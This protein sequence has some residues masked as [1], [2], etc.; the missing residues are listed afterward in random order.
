MFEGKLEGEEMGSE[1]LSSS[2]HS[3][4]MSPSADKENCCVLL[5]KGSPYRVV[6]ILI[7]FLFLTIDVIFYGIIFGLNKLKGSIYING[8]VAGCADIVSAGLLALFAERIPRKVYILTTWA[9]VTV[10]TL[11]YH[12]CNKYQGIEYAAVLLGKLGAT[13]T[14]SMIFFIAVETFPTQHRSTMMGVSNGFARVGGAVA[15][16]LSDNVSWFMLVF[17]FI[18][19]VSFVCSLFLK[20]TKGFRLLDQVH[21]KR[22]GEDEMLHLAVK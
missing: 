14:F 21:Q 15:P 11:I 13:S 1:V 18:G 8:I 20:E 10:A 5:R 6:T 12:F 17:A 22:K 3:D 19:A 16:I 7:P 4:A 9:T 2:P